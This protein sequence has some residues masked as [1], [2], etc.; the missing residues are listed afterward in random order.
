MGIKVKYIAQLQDSDTGEIIDE[1]EIKAKKI[2][3]PKSFSDFGLRHKDQIE[4]IKN[5]QD[6]LLNHQAKLFSDNQKCP[7]CGKQSAKKGSF[8]S[9]FHDVFTDHKVTIHRLMCQ[10]GWKNKFT[11]N[12]IYGKSIH[13]ELAKIQA[14]AG[15]KNSFAQASKYLNDICYHSR[16]INNNVTVMRTVNHVGEILDRCKKS[17]LWAKADIKAKEIIVCTDG[18]H[19]QDRAEGKHSFEEMITTCYRP[20][21]RVVND[22]GR[23]EILNKVCVAGSVTQM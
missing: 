14:F 13:P 19:V 21:D 7:K 2:N 20:I 10:C 23:V 11:I 15:S 1:C 4:L 3:F 6:F 22:K 12:G 16:K 5:A 8:E 18:G 9:D 17:S